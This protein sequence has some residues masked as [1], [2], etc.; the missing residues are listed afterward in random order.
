MLC[1]IK[2]RTGKESH[3]HLDS[4]NIT[5]EH[6]FHQKGIA[7]HASFEI[8]IPTLGDFERQMEFQANTQPSDS[9]SSCDAV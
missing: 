8:N 4:H 2:E 1:S 3:I 6:T 5:D 9:V 7:S